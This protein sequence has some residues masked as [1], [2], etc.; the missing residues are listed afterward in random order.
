[1]SDDAQRLWRLVEVWLLAVDDL[2]T[3]VADLDPSDGLVA[4]DLPGWNVADNLAHLAHLEAVLAGA[5][6]HDVEV[7]EAPHL[8]RPMQYYTEA[9]VLARRGRLLPELVE[10]LREAVTTRYA[11][12]RADPPTDASAPPPRTP[13]GVGWDT[14]TVLRNRPFDVWLHEQDIRRA[15]GRPGGLD[16]APARHTLSVLVA[17]L[18]MVVGKRV[19]PEVGRGVRLELPQAGLGVTAVVGDDGRARFDEDAVP[20][21]TV[22]LTTEDYVVLAAG[23]RPP[24]ATAPEVEGDR[25]LAARLLASL[26]VTP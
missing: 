26:A 6:E 7:P 8:Q 24:E 12:L 10:E 2:T 19:A 18:P 11:A 25:E 3:L 21:T 23:R 20:A 1:M 17:G 9:G 4:T 14:G 5:P 16:G 15:L 22:R 13:G